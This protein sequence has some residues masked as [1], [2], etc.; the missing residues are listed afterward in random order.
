MPTP[1]HPAATESRRYYVVP[2]NEPDG[3]VT[4]AVQEV[5][6]RPG[7]FLRHLVSFHPAFKDAMT[8]RDVA[9]R[10]AGIDHAAA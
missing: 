4:H 8:A 1:E 5:V 2:Y 10:K 6:E 3:R 7:Y 9:Y